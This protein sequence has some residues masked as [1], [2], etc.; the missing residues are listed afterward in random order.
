MKK[1]VV[2]S[3]FGLLI[4]AFSATV[5]AQK[6]D[7]KASGFIDAATDW[8]RNMATSNT[9]AGIYQTLPTTFLPGGG[10]YDKTNA[11][12]SSRTR[13][14]FDAVMEKNLSGTIFFEMDSSRWGEVSPAADQRNAYGYWSGDRGAVE[15]KNIYI[16]FGVPGVPVPMTMRVG[17]QPLAIRPNMLVLTDGMGVTMGIKA[18]PVTIAPLWFKA[19]EGQDA[20]SDDVDVYGVHVS[21]KADTFTLGGYGLYYDMESYPFFSTVPA[22]GTVTDNCAEMWWLGLYADGKAGPVDLNFDLILDDGKVKSRSGLKS[23]DYTGWATRLKIDYPW[24]KFNFGLVG[25]YASGADANK[26]PDPKGY[27]DGTNSKVK[28]Y[29]TPPGSEAPAVFNESQV[30]Y[31]TPLDRTGT[32][33]G[34]AWSYTG[35]SRGTIGGTWMAKLYGSCKVSPVYKMTLQGLYIGDT[36]KNGNTVGTAKK[37]DGTLRDDKSIGWEFDL[38]NEFQ[39]YKNLKYTIGAGF[40]L[41]GDALKYWDSDAEK[42]VKPDTPWSIISMI[43]YN[44]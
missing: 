38:I 7:F 18:D 33:I 6:L 43:I 32:G 31:G 17:L 15:V 8:G 9:G 26:T 4:M 34:A 1:F 25:M 16:D 14:K 11:W 24:E 35:L 20:T 23:V 39:I 29:V 28:S 21:G 13:L 3:L 36:T 42:N 41:P 40:L 37:A 10:A 12:M 27:A 5:Y 19:L 2:L 30:F 22:Y 44:F